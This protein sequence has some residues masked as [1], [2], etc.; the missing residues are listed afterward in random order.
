MRL[1]VV[2]FVVCSWLNPLTV[3]AETPD[4]RFVAGLLQRRLFTLAELECQKQLSKADQTPREQVTWTV[5]LVRIH[6]LHAA[7]SSPQQRSAR[8]QAAH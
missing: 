8:W 4:E 3:R 6:A 1:L 7:N 5:E 2:L